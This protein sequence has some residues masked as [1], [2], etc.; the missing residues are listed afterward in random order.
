MSGGTSG[1]M[2]FGASEVLHLQSRAYPLHHRSPVSS[3]ELVAVP[4]H[5]ELR[6]VVGGLRSL[7]YNPDTTIEMDLTGMVGPAISLPGTEIVACHARILTAGTVLVVYALRHEADLRRMALHDLDA[8]DATVNQ[9]LREADAPILTAVLAAAVA[10]GLVQGIALRPDL[11]LTGAGSPIDRQSARY[12][13]HFVTRDPPWAADARVPALI[14][15]PDCRILLP[16]TYAWDRDPATPLHDLL[17]MTEPTDIAVAQQSLLVGALVAGRWVLA[18]LAH[19][20][21]ETTDVH[22]FRRFL[23]GLWADFHHLDGYRIESTQAH[24][25][26]YLSARQVIGL[27]DTQERAD[28]L[29]GYVSNSLLA[30]SSQRAEAL[31]ARL[32]RVAAALTVVSAASFGLD[33]AVFVLPQVSLATKLG[34]VTG[35]LGMAVCCLLAVVLPRT[36]RWVARRRIPAPRA[37]ADD[38]RIFVP[39]G[40]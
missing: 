28:K 3:L 38:E 17:T 9:A 7:A 39:H 22:A 26:S 27:D 29:L 21:P 10:S 6:P 4:G 35:L 8:L 25:A 13:C 23:D 20:H 12:N 1:S 19:G 14:S 37:A 31:D 11:A 30:A 16:Y 15:G 40:R 36:P 34:V 18:D 32:N 33:I 5:G 24:R 2:S